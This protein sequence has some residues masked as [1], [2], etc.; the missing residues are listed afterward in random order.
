MPASRR[1][2]RVLP[3]LLSLF[4][5][6]AACADDANEEGAGPGTTPG[7]QPT[8]AP[9]RGGT[10]VDLQNFASQGEPNHID[11]A[12]ADTVQGSQPGQLV[13]DGL[14]ETNY[15]TGELEP[16]VA[17]S[18]ESNPDA[19]VWTFRLR[20][21]V[22][23][24]NGDPVLPSDFKFAWER[25]VQRELASEI[26]Y[27][28][29]PIK[30]KAEVDAGTTRELTGVRADDEGRVLTVELA[31]PYSAFPY[32]VSHLVFSPVPA[33]VLRALPDQTRWE[34][35]VMIG[36]GPFKM[37]EPWQHDHSITL[38]RNEDYWGGL[39]GHD[40]YLDEVV[41]RI[42]KDIDSAFADFEAGNGQTG[43]IPPGR[44]AEARAKYRGRTAT[45]PSLGTYFWVFNM[46]DPAVGGPD[47]KKLREAIALA[48]DRRAIVE[49]VYSGSREVA[50]AM[51]PPNMPG[52]QRGL[53]KE[54]G[55]DLPRA[56][57]LMQEYGRTPPP[58]KLNFNAGAGHEPVATIVQANLKDIGIDS[59]LDGRDGTTYFTTIKDGTGQFSRSGWIAD[60][61]AYD[62]YTY[63]LFHTEAIGGDNLGQYS[64]PRVDQLI[65]EARRTLDEGERNAKY[66]EAE[67]IVLDDQ[68][69]VP[70]NWYTGAI[71]YDRSVKNFVQ[72]PLQLVA[73]D[74][75]FLQR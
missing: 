21:D 14:T 39:N 31:F 15:K 40:A 57:Q 54:A 46:K 38:V 63:P 55:R 28:F 51:T 73:Y 61:V 62:N 23:F 33:N 36:N 27:H 49:A 52:Y 8:G 69:A 60:Y 41:F 42:S 56:R 64:N 4:L 3:F 9:V 34:Q 12:L 45:E 59:Q 13:F 58:L 72:S 70:L 44:F 71:A 29:D 17:Q 22:R 11:P 30:G 47:N 24:S 6:A 20:R 75:I 26:A 67:R 5:L 10:L 35:G 66:Q 32:T 16:M 68:V 50:T 2:R 65:N 48:I 43:Y 1:S 25:A 37:K 53:D 7:D 74:E 19:T 18:Y